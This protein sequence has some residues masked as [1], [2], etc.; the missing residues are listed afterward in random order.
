MTRVRINLLEGVK[1]E[2]V[3]ESPYLPASPAVFQGQVFLAG[4]MASALLL[5]G[6]Y[7]FLN[8]R[9][10]ELNHQMEA[11]RREAARLA[12]I[13]AATSRYSAE[14]QDVNRRIEVLQ[15]LENGRRGPEQL[16]TQLATMVNGAPEL[17][18]ISVAP[19][20]GRI[21]LTGAASSVRSIATFVRSLQT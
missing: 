19:Q 10:A 6:A 16:M 1:R 11:E 4:R 15:L 2:E 12:V 7:W 14:L 8:R 3:E 17:Y 5:A 20:A 13:Q 18:L 9:V 21:A